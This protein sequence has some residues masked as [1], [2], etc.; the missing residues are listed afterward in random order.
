MLLWT[1]SQPLLYS[2]VPYCLIKE[3]FLNNNVDFT[4][5]ARHHRWTN[6][7]RVRRQQKRL[8]GGKGDH[9]IG[10]TRLRD[11]EDSSSVQR[12]DIG[13]LRQEQRQQAEQEWVQGSRDGAQQAGKPLQLTD[14]SV[15][16]G[17]ARSEIF[18]NSST[19]DIMLSR[20]G[21]KDVSSSLLR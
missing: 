16:N 8:P 2:H 19:L 3:S 14:S 1:T 15:V 4:T 20:K 6:V 9:P 17:Y 18:A 11:S 5:G 7:R 10:W 21:S 12:R 13:T